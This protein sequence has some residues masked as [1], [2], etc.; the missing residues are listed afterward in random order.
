MSRYSINLLSNSYT[1][2]G[3]LDEDFRMAYNSR[4]IVNRS[5][6][7]SDKNARR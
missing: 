7:Q 1:T 3:S 4:G 5:N 2:T 6:H